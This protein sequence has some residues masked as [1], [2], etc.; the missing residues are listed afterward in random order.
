VDTRRGIAAVTCFLL[1][2]AKRGRFSQSAL[3]CDADNTSA[4]GLRYSTNGFRWGSA[5]ME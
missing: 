3:H 5:S 4:R 1:I 2:L